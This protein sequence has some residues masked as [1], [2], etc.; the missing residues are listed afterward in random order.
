M[1]FVRLLTA[2]ADPV[3]IP[4]FAI[5]KMKSRFG[6]GSIAAPSYIGSIC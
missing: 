1:I 2:T 3:D 6:A 4:L 5:Y